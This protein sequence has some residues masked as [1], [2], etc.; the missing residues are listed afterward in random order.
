[1]DSKEQF[2]AV[3]LRKFRFHCKPCN[4]KDDMYEVI[5]HLDVNSHARAK[6]HASG[7]PTKPAPGS[8]RAL[9]ECEARR[10]A[11]DCPSRC[12]GA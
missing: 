8:E 2:G 3:L 11:I 6:S 4:K 9:A 1:M 10:E 5:E 12:L 7:L